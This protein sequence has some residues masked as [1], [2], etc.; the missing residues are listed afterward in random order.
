MEHVCD[1]VLTL[2]ERD[3]HLDVLTCISLLEREISITSSVQTHNLYG[4]AYM[5]PVAPAHK[6]IVKRFLKRLSEA[7]S[8]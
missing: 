8:E 1:T 4:K 6:V 2:S 5:L 7:Q 3:R